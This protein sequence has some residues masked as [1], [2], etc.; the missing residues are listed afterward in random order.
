MWLLMCA[1]LLQSYPTLCN[2]IDCKLPGSSVYGISQARILEWVAIS[3]S[4]GSS[5]LRNQTAPALAGGFFTTCD[6]WRLWLFVTYNKWKMWLDCKEKK[7]CKKK[8]VLK[9]SHV[10]LMGDKGDGRSPQVHWT[11]SA[12]ATRPH[13][14]RRSAT[15]CSG[16]GGPGLSPHCSG[17]DRG[18]SVLGL[19]AR[20]LERQWW[21][22][23]LSA[24]PPGQ[25]AVTCAQLP[26]F[27][28]NHCFREE[29]CLGR[30]G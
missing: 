10:L 19:Q 20:Q 12:W 14:F 17:R 4:R 25:D 11:P 27:Y 22:L 6:T 2:P 23:L 5:Q 29:A 18:H 24:E 1:H 16:S 26:S 15:G 21:Q 28:R 9:Q 3:P 7:S 13:V 30:K 8:K